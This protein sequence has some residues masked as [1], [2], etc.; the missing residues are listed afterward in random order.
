AAGGIRAQ[1][2]TEINVRASLL[3]LQFWDRFEE[4][5]GSP[6]AFLRTGY[7]MLATSTAEH[8]DL[9]ASV[10]LQNSLGIP[11]RMVDQDEMHAIVPQMTVADLAG[12]AYNAD[13]GT[14]SPYDALQGY[15]GAAKARG[16]RII[17]EARVDGIEVKRGRVEAVRLSNGD[18]VATPMVVNAAGPW[19]G[20]VGALAGV[21]VPVRPFRREIYVSEPFPRLPRGP[22]VMDLHVAWYYRHEGERILMSGIADSFS[23]W[24]TELDRSKLPEVAALAV[25]R[26]P[27]L[28]GASFS[29]GWAGSYDIS[30]DNHGIVGQFPELHGFICACG[31]SGHGY[32]HSPATGMLVSE[33]ILDGKATSLDTSPLSPTRFREGRQNMERLTSHR[34]LPING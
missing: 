13:D 8:S 17:E 10:T 24:N 30:P 26:L 2:S 20:E 29:S 18:R 27:S 16:V 12:G 23:S 19:S 14:G 3:S 6:H 34:E 5:T 7:L 1:F 11:S 22:L 25:H 28:A 31:F 32:M 21:E 4:E 33:L 15:I 9:S